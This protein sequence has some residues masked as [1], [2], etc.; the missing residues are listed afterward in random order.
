[1]S[2]HKYNINPGT[3]KYR[4]NQ[5]VK[6][7]GCEATIICIFSPDDPRA[8]P[9]RYRVQFPDGTLCLYDEDAV[10]A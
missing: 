4:L 5:I 7:G 3:S 10:I 6:V 1:M 9:V 8:G 2:I